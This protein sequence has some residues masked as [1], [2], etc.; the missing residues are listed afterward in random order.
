MRTCN[1][2]SDVLHDTVQCQTEFL[3]MAEFHAFAGQTSLDAVPICNNVNGVLNEAIQCYTD[4]TVI[5]ELITVAAQ[6]SKHANLQQRH[7]N[8][9]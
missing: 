4:N 5:T 3:C 1:L 9:E 6:V 7:W 2:E 8:S